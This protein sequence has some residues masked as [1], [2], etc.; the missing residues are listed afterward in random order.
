MYNES[1]PG[2][3]QHSGALRKGMLGFMLAHEQFPASELIRL[4]A[5]AEHAGFDLL[6]TSDHFQP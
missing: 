1:R 2:V 3:E 5:A 4:G 6:A